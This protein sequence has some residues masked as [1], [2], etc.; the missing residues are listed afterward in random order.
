MTESAERILYAQKKYF[1][2]LEQGA[3]PLTARMRPVRNYYLACM[4]ESASRTEE[5]QVVQK[6]SQEILNLKDRKQISK[7]LIDRLSGP[8]GSPLTFD[9]NGDQTRPELYDLGFFVKLHLFP[10]KY[11]YDQPALVA[12]Y[13]TILTQMFTE[14][15]ITQPETRAQWIL[16]AELESLQKYP[17]PAQMRDVYSANTYVDRKVL[18]ARYPNL[19]LLKFVKKFPA[20]MRVRDFVPSTLSMLD[21]AIATWPEDKLKSLLIRFAVLNLMDDAYPDFFNR[22]FEFNKKYF[23]G[24]LER[25]VR[26]ERCTREV[27]RQFGMELAYELQSVLYPNFDSQIVYRQIEGVRTAI[28]N[29]LKN[30]NWLSET[31]RQEAINKIS[32]AQL[33][34]VTPKRTEDWDFNLRTNYSADTPYAN[35]FK[36]R[37][38]GTE[39]TISQMQHPRNRSVWH[40]SPHVVNAYYNPPDNA[41]VV[42]QAI[43]RYPIFDH[44]QT[45]EENLAAIGTIAGHELGHAID[46]QG[47]KYDHRGIVRNWRTEKD[48]VEFQARTIGLVEQ[49]NKTD[50]N[51]QLTLGENIGDLVGITF[52]Y[53]TAFANQVGT[54]T[55]LDLTRRKQFFENYG[56]MWCTKSRPE[57]EKI[58]KESG[59]H[60]L[61]YA[62]VNEPL[63]NVNAF[64][65]TFGC[66][67]GDKMY[68][69]P[70]KRIRI[71]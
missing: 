47:A 67:P 50:H 56:R 19:D 41:F 43:L 4:N 21:V 53:Q 39:K 1:T 30:N 16:D 69:P 71:W 42:T 7:Y 17:T 63:K 37:R 64:Y 45:P 2:L 28:V 49:Y 12:E 31:G 58:K 27:T 32:K 6:I 25:P 3:T 36:F 18:S 66:K 57:A 14:L 29:G 5:R 59:P 44:L 15:E 61:G 20:S 68:L 65:E 35:R 9:Q 46:D 40:M 26:Q 33:S 52:S 54:S 70:E 24:P 23:G 8:Y 22:Y 13:K 62:R 60:P 51:G 34:L 48:I 55:D 10:T 38:L 11:Y